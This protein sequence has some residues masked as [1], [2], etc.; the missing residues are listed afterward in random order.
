MRRLTST[1]KIRNKMEIIKNLAEK[2]ARRLHIFSNPH[3]KALRVASLGAAPRN[4]GTTESTIAITTPTK[5]RDHTPAWRTTAPFPPF[6]RGI[7][8]REKYYMS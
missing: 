8:R 6:K 7:S 3:S 4:V 2:G 1:S 5:K